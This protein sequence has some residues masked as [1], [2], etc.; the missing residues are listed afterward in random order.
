[1]TSEVK[2]KTYFNIQDEIDK[3]NISKKE[4]I[5]ALL[6]AIGSGL[7]IVAGPI[8][9]FANLMMFTNYQVTLAFLIALMVILF[10]FLV[11]FIYLHLITKRQVEGL[12]HVWSI[13][14]LIITFVVLIVCFILTKL[15][16]KLF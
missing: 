7:A 4:K 8:A 6:I 11:D 12:Y 9:I 1:M 5:I 14:V 2:N 13:N 16:F 3:L 15:V 10:A